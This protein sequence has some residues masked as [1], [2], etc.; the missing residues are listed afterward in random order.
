MLLSLG[1]SGAHWPVYE[2]R[3]V[4]VLLSPRLRKASLCSEEKR[5]KKLASLDSAYVM[6]VMANNKNK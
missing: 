3:T 6:I 5:F 4:S 2:V 1:T